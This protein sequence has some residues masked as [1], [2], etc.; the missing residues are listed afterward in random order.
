MYIK[1]ETVTSIQKNKLEALRD[2]IV[3]QI[4]CN[5]NKDYPVT[6]NALEL[7]NI[8]D[9][10]L[11]MYDACDYCLYES[12]DALETTDLKEKNQLIENIFD[13]LYEIID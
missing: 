12:T 1:E 9:T 10:W 13:E 3:R 5:D 11:S 4:Y 7:A 2:N 8:L 6:L